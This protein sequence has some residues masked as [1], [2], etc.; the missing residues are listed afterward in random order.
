MNNN[1]IDIGKDNLSSSTFGIDLL[2]NNDKKRSSSKHSA[3][4]D[5]EDLNDLE[6]EL[7]DLTFN[8]LDDGINIK[9]TFDSDL[10]SENINEKKISFDDKTGYNDNEPNVH[11]SIGQSTAQ[12]AEDLPTWDGFQKFNNIPINLEKPIS[13]QPQM[14]KEELLREKFKILRKLETL[15]GKGIQLSKKYNMDSPL[16]EMQGEYETIVDEKNKTNSIKFQGNMM[17]AI[18]NGLEF[19]NGK[20]DPFDIKLDGFSDQITE[21]IN[22]YDDIFGELYEKYKSR[23]SMS[24]E[25]KLLFQL[26]GAGIMVH[27]TNT[28]FKTTAPNVDD[29]F[30]QNPDLMKSFQQAAMN[31][32]SNSNPGFSGFM[33]GLMNNQNSSD[34]NG[35]PSPLKTQSNKPIPDNY[36]TRGGNNSFGQFNQSNQSFSNSNFKDDG[37]HFQEKPFKPQTPNFNF[38]PEPINQKPPS[39]EQSRRIRAEM[40]GPSDISDVLSKL[41]TKTINI[42]ETNNNLREYTDNHSTVSENDLREINGNI[43]LPLKKNRKQKS[44]KNIS[45]ISL[46][47]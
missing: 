31:S 41:K 7:N 18:I 36:S 6:K 16:A 17:M 23:A 8:D 45:S 32:M 39:L 9:Q 3:D 21:N 11:S 22:D 5:F 37:I 2:M 4:I 1:I 15:D 29:I 34:M 25:L 35:P 43:K 20:Y 10:F 40:K 46:D 47:I 28:M 12:T 30:K 33:S 24:P 26:G 13:S 27:M 38:Q 44:D 14:T 42:N 19:L